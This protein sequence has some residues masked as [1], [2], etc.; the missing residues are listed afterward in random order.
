MIRLLLV[1]A[2]TLLPAAARADEPKP[3]LPPATAV[4][5][6]GLSAAKKDGKAVFL[7]FGSPACGW[8]K[9]L[10]KYH[11]RPAV[12]KT[13]GKHL[14]FVKVDVIENEGGQKLYEKYAPEP[15]GVP[16]WVVLSAEGKVLGD[17][18]ADK[19]GKKDN[20]G[21]PYEPNEVAHYEKVLRAALPKLTDAEV[22]EVVKELK[23]A[24]P[25][26]DKK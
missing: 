19:N 21:F 20:V 7:A 9:Y 3:K 16:V 2:L 8:C 17:S 4:L 14:V 5:A 24:G 22:A 18:F 23:D 15:G 10:D 26:R 11:A 13:L 6:E 25:K 12:A 1:S